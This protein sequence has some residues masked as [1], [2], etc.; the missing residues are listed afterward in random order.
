MKPNDDAMPESLKP[1][2]IAPPLGLYPRRFWEEDVLPTD[3]ELAN[4]LEEINAAIAR[5]KAAGLLINP[6]W[7]QEAN[8][9]LDKLTTCFIIKMNESQTA[10]CT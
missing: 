2:R 8:D 6:K 5:Y 4:R 7:Q 9:I 3:V 1:R 10:H